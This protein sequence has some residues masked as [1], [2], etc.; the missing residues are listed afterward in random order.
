ML[1]SVMGLRGGD[2][3]DAPRRLRSQ[4]ECSAIKSG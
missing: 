2:L 3:N 1:W 4:E